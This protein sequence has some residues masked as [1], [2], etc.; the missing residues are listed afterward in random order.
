ML[1]VYIV[2]QYVSDGTFIRA[3]DNAYKN[4][5]D[6]INFCERLTKLI[7]KHCRVKTLTII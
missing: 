5:E 4:K 2:E 3:N 7:N 1:F 6:A